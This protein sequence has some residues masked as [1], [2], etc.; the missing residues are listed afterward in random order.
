VT[1]PAWRVYSTGKYPGKL[2][3]FWHQ[4][5]DPQTWRLIHA[6]LHPLSLGRPVGLSQRRRLPYWHRRHARHLPT[7]SSGRV[8]GLRWPGA[9]D[10]GYTYPEHLAEELERKVS[11]QP[12]IKSDF[13]EIA[14]EGPEAKEAL[15]VIDRTFAAAEYLLDRDTVQ[16]L[17]VTTFDINRLQ[18]VSSTARRPWRPGRSGPLARAA[19]TRFDYTLI[20]SDH[21]TERLD[22]A[23]L[24]QRLACGKTAT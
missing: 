8:H 19:Y 5:L 7:P 24:S 15:R 6:Q 12:T 17:Q 23:F 22:R 3:V 11:Y 21:G 13:A 14:P 1:M 16:F 10:S 18:H 20:M 9:A 2:G 4:Q